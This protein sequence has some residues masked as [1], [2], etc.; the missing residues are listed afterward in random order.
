MYKFYSNSI[1]DA[2]L[3]PECGNI[4]Q[5]HY[6]GVNLINFDELKVIILTD[7]PGRFPIT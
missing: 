4:D 5:K 7:L 2:P 6:I 3:E 1:L